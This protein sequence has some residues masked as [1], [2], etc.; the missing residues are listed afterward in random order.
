MQKYLLRIIGILLFFSGELY[1]QTNKRN[2]P[3]GDKNKAIPFELVSKRIR[4]FPEG[5]QLS[6]AV[7]NNG[8]VTYCGYKR[9]ADAIEHTDNH[10]K[11]FEIGSIAKIFTATLL[12]NCIIEGTLKP[13]DSI[14]DHLDLTIGTSEKITFRQLASHT[15]GLPRLP[16]NLNL[17]AV[18]PT[19]PYRDYGENELKEYLKEQIQFNNNPGTTY[20]YSNLG[21]GLLGYILTEISG[22]S[23]EDMLH[24]I[25]FS[26]YNMTASTTDREKAQDK[27]VPGLNHKG[28]E[29]QGWD[30][31]VLVGAGGILSTAEDLSKFALA[32]F[33]DSNAT[34]QLTQQS[35]FTVSE[36]ME[37][38]LGWHILPNINGNPILWHT[39]GTGGYSSSIALDKTNKNG[40]IILSNVST[41]HSD[42]KNIDYLCFDLLKE[43]Y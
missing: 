26:R 40:V 12:A 6:V 16:S 31:N 25:I 15:S 41:F 1:G 24:N 37:T 34:L 8:E 30:F 28:T 4:Q 21:A 9:I 38:G 7:I 13:D 35:V 29:T 22:K 39:G 43:I 23:Y 10:R 36:T 19:N 3:A 20:E 33:D 2:V 17:L 27:L 11:L 32:Q 42:M 18:N 14:Q 5:T